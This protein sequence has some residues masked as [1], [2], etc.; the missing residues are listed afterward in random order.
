MSYQLSLFGAESFE[1]AAKQDEKKSGRKRNKAWC[2][3]IV[4][5]GGVSMSAIEWCKKNGIPRRNYIGRRNNLPNMSVLEAVTKPVGK[6]G[7]PHRADTLRDF[8][9]CNYC[10]DYEQHLCPKKARRS[11][12]SKMWT[13]V[14]C[15]NRSKAKILTPI[16]RAWYSMKW[17]VAMVDDY[18]D[19][20]IDE[21]WRTS[22]KAFRE[23]VM[24]HLGPRPPGL[25]IDRI[26]SWKGY[27]RGNIR[28]AT[29]REQNNNKR[30]HAK[31]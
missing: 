28:W 29:I 31:S 30:F 4:T 15:R 6:R 26:N 25:T 13:C 16:R 2:E 7:R 22:F 5:I 21:E 3:E 24:F 11:D 9:F 27:V 10:L 12:G 14:G 8:F 23:Y 19:V 20:D 17:R 1:A 18:K